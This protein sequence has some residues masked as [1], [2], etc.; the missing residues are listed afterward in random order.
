MRI[1]NSKDDH[2]G[3]F[4]SRS[5]CLNRNAAVQIHVLESNFFVKYLTIDV[6]FRGID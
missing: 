2:L 3:L 1:S 6:Y 5:A 4:Y